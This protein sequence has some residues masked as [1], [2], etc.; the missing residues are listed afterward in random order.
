MLCYATVI[1][2]VERAGFCVSVDAD[3]SAGVSGGAGVIVGA[4][5]VSVSVWCLLVPKP[6]SEML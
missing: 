3:V 1:V 4:A 5:S 2:G 6:T